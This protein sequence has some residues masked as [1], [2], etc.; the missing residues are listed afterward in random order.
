MGTIASK[1]Y[2]PLWL[3]SNRFGTIVDRKQDLSSHIRVSN[4]HDFNNRKKA[5][6]YVQ[7]P[8]ARKEFY[9]SYGL[10]FYSNNQFKNQ[11][12]QESFVKLGYKN[13][14]LR[15]GRYEE[16]IGEMEPEISSG[17]LGLSGNAL[18]IP[19]VQLA[20][21]K[22]TNIPYTNGWL[23]F[24]GHFAHGLLGKNRYMKDAFLHEKTFY[25]RIGK[26]KLRLFGSVQHYA[27]WGGRREDWRALDRSFNGF[28]DVV[29]AK[30]AD[31]GSYMNGIVKDGTVHKDSLVQY[32]PNRAG[33][34]RGVVEG[35]LEWEND[36]LRLRVYHQTPFDMGQG[37]TFKNI[38]KLMGIILSSNYA[39]NVL[40]KLTLEV[41]HTKQMNDFYPISVR[42]SYYNNGV[43]KTGWEYED[44][45]IGTPL[46]I[47]R[48]RGSQY[49]PEEIE[50]Y[51]WNAPKNTIHGLSNI[52]NNR[53]VGGHIGFSLLPGKRIR[54]RTMFTYTRNYG[55]FRTSGPFVP[56]KD[57]LYFFQELAYQ[58]PFQGLKFTGS[59][60]VDHGQ[61]TK[62]TGFSAGFE[63]VVF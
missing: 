49:F 36:K 25:M 62:N 18:P 50:A 6:L 19:K 63:W 21:D 35:G 2:Q 54:T 45:I 11:F 37:I 26:K 28:M 59:V 3:V 57:Q 24:K 55:T 30:E 51:D 7:K 34:H 8:D 9:L 46:F 29:L 23:H 10:D 15:A 22:F 56:H 27:V 14:V 32:L 16:V 47:N 5:A 13:W 4:R 33:D 44:R 41:I 12:L 48:V 31:D 61:F 52:I 1:D 53:V 17:S 20:V 43:Y 42:E 58:S 39:K 38:D 40:Q 60:G